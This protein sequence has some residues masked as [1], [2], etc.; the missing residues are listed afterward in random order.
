MKK[1][2]FYIF[3]GIFLLSS[4]QPKMEEIPLPEPHYDDQKMIEVLVDMHLTEALIATQVNLSDSLSEQTEEEYQ[5]LFKRHQI[6]KEDFKKNIE[7]LSH[8]M[9]Q[10]SSI[11]DRV[12]DSLNVLN[13]SLR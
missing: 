3:V 2:E 4:C 1:I 6:T 8:N 9:D 13:T 12:L 11:M 5:R 10:F 7:Y